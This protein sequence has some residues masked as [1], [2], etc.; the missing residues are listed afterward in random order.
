MFFAASKLL[1]LLVYPLGL[2]CLLLATSLGIF[3]RFPRVAATAVALALSCLVL[4]GNH[5]V[6]TA[7]VRSLEWQYLPLSEIPAAEAIVV[8]GGGTGAAD[9]PR[10][11]VDLNDAGDRVVYGAKLLKEG[12]A[13]QLILSGGRAAWLDGPVPEA[14]DMRAVAEAMGVSPEAIVPEPES[15]NTYENAV[16]VRR[17]LQARG[18]GRV[19]LVTSA[20]HMPRAL[21]IFRHLDIDA[22]PMPTDYWVTAPQIEPSLAGWL[23]GLMP[24]SENLHQ[25]SRAI[26]EYIGT[27]VYS[28]KGWL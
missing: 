21:A 24:D 1:P 22:I 9:Y 4:A 15:R 5:W 16:N 2:S 7:L 14:V 11:W 8:L 25:T 19:L 10:P 3:W 18:I 26:K 13:S 27:A 17:I 6:A 23:V 28:L 20:M 12:K